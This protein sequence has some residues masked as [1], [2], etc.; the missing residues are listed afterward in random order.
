DGRTATQLSA[1]RSRTDITT[2]TIQGRNAFNSFSKFDVYQ[3][4]TV[5]LHVPAST[6]NLLNLVHSSGTQIDG[7][8]NSYK[9][10]HI[11]GN[12]FFANPYGF[13]VGKSGVVNVGS[14]TA[15]TPTKGFMERFFESPG[16]PS[17]FATQQLID[18][19][20]PINASGL[21]SVQGEVTALGDIRLHGGQVIVAGSL[22]LGLG[23]TA[24]TPG[25]DAILNTGGVE[26]AV[27][28]VE[29]NGEIYILSE[30][31]AA[32]SGSL[33]ADGSDGVD[34]GRVEV[35]A[36]ED[37]VI[38]GDALLSAKGRGEN[39]NGGEVI[40]FADRDAIIRDSGVLD[41]SGGQSGNG[42]FVEFSAKKTV[43]LAGGV[44]RAS[45]G[46]GV[47]GTVLI[48]P[49]NLTISS[50]LL[51]GVSGSSGGISWDA[52][53]LV[54]DA[55]E[56]ITI[57][58]GKV[59][60]TRQVAASSDVDEH[61]TG[62]STGDSGNMTLQAKQ[63]ELQS[64]SELLA[65][66]NN[67]RASGS[68]ELKAEDSVSLLGGGTSDI[69]ISGANIHAGSITISAKSMGDDT[70]GIAAI[71]DTKASVSIGSNSNI[72]AIDGD[73]SITATTEVMAKAEGTPVDLL[74]DAAVVDVGA[75]AKV[76]VDQSTIDA[77]GKID[78]LAN[79]TVD[80]TAVAKASSTKGD[81]NGD[82]AVATNI[83][84][85]VAEVTVGGASVLSSIGKTTLSATNDIDATT[86]AD[87][88]AGGTTAAGASVAV[89]VIKST[90]IA[91]MSDAV[92]VNVVDNLELAATSSETVTT[93]VKSTAGGSI[94]N[95]TK[96]EEELKKDGRKAET[97]EGGV[98]VAAALAVS[99]LISNT[100][101]TL[102]A[103]GS[104]TVTAREISVIADSSRTVSTKTD[105]S[106]TGG[107]VGVGV[108][109]AINVADTKTR[110]AVTG[111]P[112]LVTDK[113]SVRSLAGSSPSSYTL[114]SKSGAGATNVGVAGSLAIN[115][116]VNSSEAVIEEG[117]DLDLNGADLE[118]QANGDIKTDVKAEATQ[119][120]DG[121]VGVGASVAINVGVNN[122]RAA[123]KDGANLTDANNITL[124]AG[125]DHT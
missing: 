83:V 113:L 61:R 107:G 58:A 54:L 115:V 21:I 42:G 124:T 105:A 59:V 86:T 12:I 121:K 116:V 89:A 99:D 4:N 93:T 25:T 109:V 37:I 10:G 3:G 48:D 73:V 76:A 28:V 67:G 77:S 60:S 47:A 11:G 84:D 57:A 53:N 72:Q 62:L 32:I 55:D 100:S 88:T 69:T 87:G 16:A 91:S 94:A 95:T 45:A 43:E 6:T 106:A 97:S 1:Q 80:A 38:S 92:D 14:L 52:G 102:A 120:G 35:R 104:K 2:S 64:G 75:E 123:I 96:T 33:V 8:L 20:V 41:A 108:A 114:A 24:Q 101:A 90:T 66:G 122:T 26:S 34:A 50:H 44:F 85:S 23:G 111:T 31:D 27:G 29:R 125:S 117:A 110:A 71:G 7:I 17:A 119:T 39:S 112:R 63:I 78:L 51:R 98:D 19:S 70:L 46:N 103:D 56:K 13:V 9:N 30:S 22:N 15:V 65:F 5:N 74:V 36:G 49:E 18:G 68:V 79:S 118:L 81:V 40:V 82:A